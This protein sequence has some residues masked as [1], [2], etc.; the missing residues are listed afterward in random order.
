MIEIGQ[1][2]PTGNIEVLIPKID[3]H[4][5]REI[6]IKE[7]EKIV[8]KNILSKRAEELCTLS[9][10]AVSLSARHFIDYVVLS[11]T[12]P[13]FLYKA[14]EKKNV[15]IKDYKN[16]TEGILIELIEKQRLKITSIVTDNLPVQIAALAHWSPDSILN[17]SDNP[18]I[19]KKI[20]FFHVYV[21]QLISL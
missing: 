10:D 12:T 20:V 2:N 9:L 18:K 1:Q 19:K 13:P 8:Q 5:I 7:G 15:S 11:K 17:T 4:N 16:I 3:R 6:I 21:I 14:V